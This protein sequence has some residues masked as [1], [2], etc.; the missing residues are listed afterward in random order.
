M[1]V[2]AECIYKVASDFDNSKEEIKAKV[3]ALCQKYSLYE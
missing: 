3:E 2:I 1:E